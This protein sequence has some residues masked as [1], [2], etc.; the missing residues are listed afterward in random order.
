M[1]WQVSLF[2]SMRAP[3]KAN[4]GVRHVQLMVRLSAGNRKRWIGRLLI[5]TAVGA[6]WSSINMPP[7][8]NLTPKRAVVSHLLQVWSMAGSFA[9]ISCVH[10][11]PYAD[12]ARAPIHPLCRP[13]Q[14]TLLRRV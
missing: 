1:G 4:D 10:V 12:S 6:V 8:N 5:A 9:D 11:N 7:Y 13:C 14:S 2:L 3:T